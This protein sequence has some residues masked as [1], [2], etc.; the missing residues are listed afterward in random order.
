[1]HT[2]GLRLRQLRSSHPPPT[3]LPFS[4]IRQSSPS[5]VDSADTHPL[6]GSPQQSASLLVQLDRH[7]GHV[8]LL[9]P[10]HAL[11]PVAPGVGGRSDPS[12]H[13]QTPSTKLS[14]APSHTPSESLAG[15]AASSDEA[16]A[17]RLTCWLANVIK[18]S[19]SP[20]D[21]QCARACSKGRMQPLR[22]E[23]AATRG[24]AVRV[25]GAG[26]PAPM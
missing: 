1:M 18:A 24:G 2:N 6:F 7:A 23:A 17:S 13:L 3:T 11:N 20:S 14:D 22:G 12:T 4:P 26:A 25:V 21:S 19:E 10:V 5:S 9:L 16:N 15:S 8:L